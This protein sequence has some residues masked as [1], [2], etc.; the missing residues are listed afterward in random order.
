MGGQSFSGYRFYGWLKSRGW[1]DGYQTLCANC[2]TI[3][4][5][6]FREMRGGGRLEMHSAVYRDEAGS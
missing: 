4:Y 1:P 2:N 6:E 3:K 5:V